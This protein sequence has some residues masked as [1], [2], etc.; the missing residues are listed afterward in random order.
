MKEH[1]DRETLK[2]FI[3]GQLASEDARLTDRHLA[4]CSECRDR[5]DE[6]SDQLVLQLLDSWLRPSYDEAF[7]RAADKTADRLAIISEEGRNTE[8]LAAELL[9][10]TASERRWRIANDERFQTIK[11]SQALRLRSREAWTIDPSTALELADLAVEVSRYLSTGRYGTCL[12]EDNRAEAWAYLGN[13]FRLNSDFWRA[14]QALKQAWLHH[15][16]AGEDLYTES[17]LLRCSS[18][19]RQAQGL[20]KEA[21]ELSNRAIS[22]F[23]EGQDS[24]LEGVALIQK[25]V[26][27]GYWGRYRDAIEVAHSALERLDPTEDPRLICAAK[28][29]LIWSLFNGGSPEEAWKFLNSIRSYYLEFGHQMDLP[30][31]RWLEGQIAI[32][33]GKLHEAKRLLNEVRDFFTSCSCG[34]EVFNV[35][36]DLAG[37]YVRMGSYRKARYCLSEII[38]LGE[39]LGLRQEVLEARLLYAQASY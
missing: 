34:A 12:V 19:L 26:A 13:S 33:L 24:H 38:P 20:Y 37:I 7:E 28:H 27:L 9:R 30:R 23:R 4:V 1:L 18:A 21:I 22:I 25:G 10:G 14:E 16:A 17:E 3:S 36:I 5:A 8:D 31:F 11:L 32:E 2:K 15:L 6:V 35:S 29:N 39:A